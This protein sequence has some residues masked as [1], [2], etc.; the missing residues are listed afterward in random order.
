MLLVILHVLSVASKIDLS[1]GI[2][3]TGLLI[4]FMGLKV[5]TQAFRQVSIFFLVL[6]IGGLYAYHQPVVVWMD[7]F[8]SMT[9]FISILVVMQLFVIPISAG[10][11]DQILSYWLKKI[12]GSSGELFIFTM[13]TTHILSSFLSMGTVPVVI[14]SN[15]AGH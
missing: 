1:Y 15:F 7:A 14:N 4:G 9:N 2:F 5:M 11:Y 6:G 12:C 13:L 8:N 3:F 10:K